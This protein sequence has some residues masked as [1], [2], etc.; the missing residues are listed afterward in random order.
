M[1]KL[2]VAK[3][4]GVPVPATVPAD[5]THLVCYYGPK[6]FTPSYAQ[7]ARIEL[8]IASV[9]KQTAG[10][11]EYYVFDT[12]QLPASAQDYDLYFTLA[13]NS[14]NEEGDFSPVVSVPLDRIPPTRLGQ[15]V[16]L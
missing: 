9:P 8:P 13:D 11:V 14:D 10:G 12:A 16:V 5:V 7:P 3:K 2:A 6:G 1:A 4:V 15:P